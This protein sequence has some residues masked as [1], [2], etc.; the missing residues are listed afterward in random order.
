MK[1]ITAILMQNENYYSN[2]GPRILI[3]QY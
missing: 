1:I 2:T 3:Q